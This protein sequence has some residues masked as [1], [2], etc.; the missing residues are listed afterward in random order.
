M[1]TK[2]MDCEQVA[3]ILDAYSLGASE[4]D[5]ARGLEEHVSDC[6]R[7]WEQLN[8]AQ[9]AAAM[10]ALA[11]PVEDAPA[12]LEE[13]II[14]EAARESRPATSIFDRFR[15]GWPTAAGA[16]GLAGVAALVFAAV[17]QVQL[18]DLRGDNS[19]LENLV[20]VEEQTIVDMRDIMFVFL[21]ADDLATLD[22]EPV[23]PEAAE[24]AVTYTWSQK[25]QTGFILCE[26]LPPLAEGQVYQAWFTL[27]GS[28]QS[29]GTFSSHNG[30]CNMPLG[31]TESGPPSGLGITI[32]PEGGSTSPAHGEYILYTSFGD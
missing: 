17:L 30:S 12:G 13:R 7:C 23:G 18:S 20:A 27:E 29:A 22:V 19:D 14:R 1:S 32:E 11:I 31:L 21:R 24:A 15:V 10:L 3:E 26:G 2:Q 16:F 8:E 9:R 6:V 28:P 4:P 5:E 25:D